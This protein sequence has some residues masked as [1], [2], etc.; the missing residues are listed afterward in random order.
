MPDSITTLGT[1]SFSSCSALKSVRISCG[2]SELPN[3]TFSSCTEL[4]RVT[5]PD[6]I[7][8]IGG[9][10]FD[11]CTSL[12]DIQFGKGLTTIGDS[13][14][15]WCIALRS[16][17]F[18]EGL[19]TIGNSAFAGNALYNKTMHLTSISFPD[20]LIEI[21]ERAFA[22]NEDLTNITL[23][24]SLKKIGQDAFTSCS[25]LTTVHMQEGLESIGAGAFSN[26]NLHTIRIPDSVEEIEENAFFNTTNTCLID[27]GNGVQYIGD[28]AFEVA[29]GSSIS[30]IFVPESVTFLGSAS[31]GYFAKNT[32]GFYD[33]TPLTPFVLSGKKGSEAEAYAKQQTLSFTAADAAPTMTAY[34]DAATGIIVSVPASGLTLQ[35]TVHT[36]GTPKQATASFLGIYDIQFTDA[37][38][39]PYTPPY[40]QIQFP[41][42]S[43]IRSYQVSYPNATVSPAVESYWPQNGVL[44]LYTT[45]QQIQLDGI[46]LLPGDVNADGFVTLAD[47]LM[48]Q[49]YLLHDGTVFAPDQADCNTDG[50]CNGLDL[51][52]LKRTL[53]DN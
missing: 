19:T 39:Q 32:G 3:S 28:Y 12:M 49:R 26:T 13:A 50:S 11:E 21:G 47:L 5:I 1:H 2:L 23:P 8:S 38:Q 16:L 34:R 31:L 43:Q 7:Q 4:T 9:S 44:T 48:L 24:P 42:A 10:A 33:L 53:I 46:S 37:Q 18:P 41:S 6:S 15:A 29:E 30:S 51:T 20:T 45:H 25:N 22:E 36:T 14:F 17:Q 27:L 35:V 40:M 52:I